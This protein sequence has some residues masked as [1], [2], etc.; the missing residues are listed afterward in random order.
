MN[1]QTQF[2]RIGLTNEAHYLAKQAAIEQATP[3]KGKQVYM[4]TLAVWAV[5][6]YLQGL[7]V[8][9]DLSQSFSWIPGM[10]SLYD[11]ADLFIPGVGFLECR[12]VLPGENVVSVP[13][14]ATDRFGCVAVQ[15][16]ESLQ[17]VQLIGFI[18]INDLEPEP[19]SLTALRPVETLFDHIC[20]QPVNAKPRKIDVNQWFQNIFTNGW[21]T[22]ET[23][24]STQVANPV[25]NIRS[26]ELKE[27]DELI[28]VETAKLIDLGI[29][30]SGQPFSLIITI[31]IL[32]NEERDVRVRLHPTGDQICLPP[33]LEL[34]VLEETGAISQQTK[35]RNADNYMQL[36]FF[37]TR[38]ESFGIEVV[39][40]DA[41]IT[42]YFLL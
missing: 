42:E 7:K 9:T 25:T 38:G 36:A 41:S 5:N 37:G 4:N 18:E 8:S 40:A 29:Q 15:F 13:L 2:L 35:A 21:Q 22:L 34:I 10:R 39:L 16:S 12:P 6:I 26:I 32:N 28:R 20:L 33:G 1:N 11:V 14:G 19:V 24:L 3:Q 30:L 17:E 31:V 27:A 23:L